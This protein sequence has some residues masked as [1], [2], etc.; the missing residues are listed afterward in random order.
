MGPGYSRSLGSK[1]LFLKAA[2]TL[3]SVVACRKHLLCYDKNQPPVSPVISPILL[4]TLNF[5]IFLCKGYHPAGGHRPTYSL[6]KHLSVW[7]HRV[8]KLCLPGVPRSTPMFLLSLAGH[9]DPNN[10]TDV[11][12]FRLYYFAIFCF[13]SFPMVFSPWLSQ[14]NRDWLLTPTVSQTNLDLN[15]NSVIY[16]VTL[17]KLV[18][19]SKPQLSLT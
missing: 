4:I 1:A 17:G 11:L 8:L 19:Q 14:R 10:Q 9:D 5:V 12:L 7:T 13:Y 18:Y 16:C 2:S 6:E 15:P 3:F